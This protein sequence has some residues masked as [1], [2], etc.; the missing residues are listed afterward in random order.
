MTTD[1]NAWARDAR[2]LLAEFGAEWHIAVVPED[3]DILICT[4][5]Q[6][7]ATHVIA[8]TPR[9]CLDRIRAEPSKPAIVRADSGAWISGPGGDAA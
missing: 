6:G 8:G 9:M 5:E 1:R 4:R 2:T 7:T 3:T